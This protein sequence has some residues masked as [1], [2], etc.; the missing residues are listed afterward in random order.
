MSYIFFA[1]LAATSFAISTLITKFVGKHIFK[2]WE[3]LWVYFLVTTAPLS[4]IVV[5]FIA[6]TPWPVQS[7]LPILSSSILIVVALVFFYKGLLVVDASILAPLFQIQAA[8]IAILAFLLLGER[9]PLTNYLWL[10]LIIAGSIIVAMDEKLDLNTFLKPGI[11]NIIL[12]NLLFAGSNV[13]AGVALKSTSS[14]N[15]I[16]W[17]SVFNLIFV[18]SFIV[19][20]RPNLKA[21]ARQISPMIVA[22]AFQFVA[23]SSLLIAYRENLTISGVFGMLSAPIVFVISV[24]ASKFYPKLLE[25]HNAKVYAIR[26]LGLL[27]ILFGAIKITLG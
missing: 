19:F 14:W 3:K 4:L 7:L 9:F 13:A 10:A 27:I 20:R 5:P 12:A 21:S 22:A 2:T 15:V 24:L 16:F 18:A 1:F 11:L 17:T 6:P 8:V 23:V 26:G 25:H